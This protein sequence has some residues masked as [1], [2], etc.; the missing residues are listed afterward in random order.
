MEE[1]DLQ[2][3]PEQNARVQRHHPD[4]IRIVGGLHAAAPQ[5]ALPAT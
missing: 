4:E 2:R 5:R 3:R 1:H